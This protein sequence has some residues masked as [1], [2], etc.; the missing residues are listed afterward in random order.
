[1]VTTNTRLYR[2]SGTRVRPIADASRRRTD[3]RRPGGRAHAGTRTKS[4]QERQWVF[5]VPFSFHTELWWLRG[6]RIEP[7]T[8]TPAVMRK[9]DGIAMAAFELAPNFCSGIFRYWLQLPPSRGNE[10]WTYVLEQWVSYEG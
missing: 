4:A 9:K 5:T 1:M 10:L 7:Y 2:V 3:V 6:S 8:L